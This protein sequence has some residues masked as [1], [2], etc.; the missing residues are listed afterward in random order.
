MASRSRARPFGLRAVRPV[1]L[2]VIASDLCSPD[3]TN[4]MLRTFSEQSLD[5]DEVVIGYEVG[6]RDV[7]SPPRPSDGHAKKRSA[8]VLPIVGVA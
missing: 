4:R 8:A 6:I 3:E 1:V 2:I 5:S 7:Q